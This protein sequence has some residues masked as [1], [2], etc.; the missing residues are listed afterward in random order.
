MAWR[1]DK[2][3]NYY[4]AIIESNS[5]LPL[6]IIHSNMAELTEVLKTNRVLEGMLEISKAI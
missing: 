1:M 2:W 3:I 5:E 4:Y 6:W